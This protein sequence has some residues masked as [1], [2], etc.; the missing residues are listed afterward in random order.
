MYGYSFYGGE[1]Y[2][3]TGQHG[4]VYNNLIDTKQFVTIINSSIK[5]WANG[6]SSGSFIV[7]VISDVIPYLISELFICKAPALSL[8]FLSFNANLF[9]TF[10]EK[11]I[12]SW[13]PLHIGQPFIVVSFLSNLSL[14]NIAYAAT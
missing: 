8:Y 12:A 11:I 5:W 7:T 2:L 4:N 14:F 9:N 6:A 10:V 3:N 13:Y 1:C